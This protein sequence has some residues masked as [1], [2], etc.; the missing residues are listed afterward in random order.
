MTPCQR[1]PA[2]G[3]DGWPLNGRCRLHGGACTSPKSVAGKARAALNLDAASPRDRRSN[4]RG[5]GVAIHA[6]R[7]GE[8]RAPLALAA[9]DCL[10]IDT[11]G[12]LPLVYFEAP[13][14][15]ISYA[16]I[17]GL[18][19]FATSATVGSTPGQIR[20]RVKISNPRVT[21]TGTENPLG[22]RP[23]RVFIIS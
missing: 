22:S 20:I 16:L 1:P 11:G 23:H 7:I 3:A 10:H 12:E 8:C 4:P 13:R 6:H 18:R 19:E 14:T 5:A 21:G 2:K 17:H 9:R 15:G